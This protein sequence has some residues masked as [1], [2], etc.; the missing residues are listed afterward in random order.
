MDTLYQVFGY[1][2]SHGNE[3]MLMLLK[4]AL[5]RAIFS[6]T[7][8]KCQFVEYSN[9]ISRLPA[10]KLHQVYNTSRAIEQMGGFL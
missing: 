1:F 8:K 6:V 2:G 4:L 3:K 5:K 10:I 9:L 7:T